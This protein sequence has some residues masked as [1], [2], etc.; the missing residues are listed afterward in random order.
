MN[1]RSKPQ[2]VVVTGASGGVGRA[3]AHAFAK[4]GAHVALRARGEQGLEAARREVEA[5]GGTALVLPTDVADPALAP[6]LFHWHL[7][8]AGFAS[9]QIADLPVSGRANNLFEPVP[10]DAA[11]HGMFDDQAHERSYQLRANTHRP[12]LSGALTGIVNGAAGL[13]RRAR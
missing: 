12:L 2:V 9:Q 10:A 6:R 11:T 1:A 4:R 5:L 3:V 8:R 7:A 13:V